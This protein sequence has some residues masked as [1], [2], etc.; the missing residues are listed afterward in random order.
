MQNIEPLANV[1]AL[2]R[3]LPRRTIAAMK[4]QSQRIHR[5]TDID[6]VHQ[7]SNGLG[8]H[9]QLKFEVCACGLLRKS[10][11]DCL[12]RVLAFSGPV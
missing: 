2:Q 8:R 12:L 3:Q 4:D 10:V 9:G 7:Y 1:W 5:L 11:F 6:G